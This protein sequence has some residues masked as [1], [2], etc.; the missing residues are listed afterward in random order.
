VV[1][2]TQT[3]FDLFDDPANTNGTFEPAGTFGA[4]L[5]DLLRMEGNYTF[6]FQATYGEDCTATRELLWSLHVDIGID[7]TRTDV[8]TT[9]GTQHPDGS[10]DVNIIINPRDKYGN[11]LGPGRTDG[12]SVNGSTGTTV[13][14]PVHDLGDGS[15]SV[16]AVWDPASGNAPGVVIGQPDKPC[17]VVQD[18]KLA[19]EKCAQWRLLFWLLLIVALGLF[20]LLIILLLLFT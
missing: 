4:P 19:Q 13:T 2:Y 12:L 14:G 20:L 17:I 9:L 3:T 6:H 15:Y 5:K 18:P 7:A 16:P 10:R 1:R 11:Y 8:S